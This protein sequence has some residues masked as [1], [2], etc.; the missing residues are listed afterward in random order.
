[1]KIIA[2]E[3]IPRDVKEWLA[4]N[5][6]NVISV[7]DINL[8]S[9][10]DYAI[11]EYAARNGIA[12][13]TLDKDFA[14]MYR[15]FQKGALTIIIIRAKPATPANIIEILK[16][17]QKRINLKTIKN[18]LVIITKKKIRIIT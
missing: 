2:D 5:G 17:A 16:I 15:M 7:S 6:F 11:A 1:M 4:K 18:K 13:I 9:D 14:L 8:R 3:N 12:I 10:K